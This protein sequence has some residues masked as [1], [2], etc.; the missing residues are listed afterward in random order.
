M[1]EGIENLAN[2]AIRIRKAACEFL[3]EGL[4]W[5]VGNK[6]LSELVADM[7]RCRRMA[8]QQ[9]QR[10]FHFIDTA[11]GNWGSK[12]DFIPRIVTVAIEIESAF[13]IFSFFIQTPSRQDSRQGD[14]IVLGVS[15]IN[16]QGMQFHQFAGVIFV[17]TAKSTSSAGTLWI[18]IAPVIQVK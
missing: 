15:P 13:T 18:G 17:Q 10:P 12:Q 4:R 3:D 1:E 5:L 2:V 6:V 9:I 14:D 8:G 11:T 7:V 16:A